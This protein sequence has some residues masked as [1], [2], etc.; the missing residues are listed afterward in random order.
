MS[1]A[2]KPMLAGKAVDFNAYPVM[3]SAKLD[4]V[5]CIVKNG[6]AL[7]RSLKPIP[8]EY[9][10][11]IL[12]NG[13]FEGLDG[14]LGIGYPGGKDFYRDTVS[15]VM[16]E[17]DQPAFV[18][19]VFDNA[20]LKPEI[21]YQKR[22]TALQKQFQLLHL[23]DNPYVKLH[24]HVTINNSQELLAY[25]EQ[26]LG[27]G[28]EGV[29]LRS[30]NGPYKYGRSST[31]EGYLLKLKRYEDAEATILDVQEL[32]KN[33]NEEFT[34]ELGRTARSSHKDNMIP[35]GTMGALN[36]KGLGGIYDGI[37]FSIGTGFDAALRQQLWNVR[38]ELIG[39]VAKFK[40]F[41]TG[42]KDAP[43]F[44]VFLGLRDPRDMS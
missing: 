33:G 31:K 11:K 25:E 5:R 35:Q 12:G 34:N 8:N 2:F 36:V 15:G 40:Y 16:R 22:Y 28:F 18:F 24:L 42:G 10:Q 6:V 21:P 23:V 9:V 7:S 43:R 17:Y 20:A 32:L 1:K 27:M 39:K 30:L 38:K 19:Y 29:I 44:P 14:E 3:A 26:C 4:G 37:E 13:N 41:A